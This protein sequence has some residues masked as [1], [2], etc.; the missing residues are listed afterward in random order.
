[1]NPRSSVYA[2]P[3]HGFT[4]IEVLLALTLGAVVV[5]AAGRSA[6][7]TLQTERTVQTAITRRVRTDHVFAAI[8]TDLDAR[9][10]AT[11]TFALDANHRPT[12]EMFA[13]APYAGSSVRRPRLP[14]TIVYGL[15]RSATNSETLRFE[16]RL[17]DDT[18]T[19]ARPI[20]TT[21]ADDLVSFDVSVLDR[22]QWEP[23]TAELAARLKDPKAFRVA[24]RFAESD[25]P[26]S[27]TFLIERPNDVKERDRDSR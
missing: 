25:G 21:I 5:A 1:M 10:D 3:R 12:I 15:T 27:R 22:D 4:L 24:C 2:V 26:I 20:T 17:R 6:I 23:L 14:S 9:I 7:L 13:L 8:T 18:H 19:D 11:V 16:R